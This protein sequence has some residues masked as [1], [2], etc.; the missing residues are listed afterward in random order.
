[1]GWC[2][3]AQYATK[4]ES[5]K[6]ASVLIAVATFCHSDFIIRL[7][8]SGSSR[9]LWHLKMG[10]MRIVIA[11]FLAVVYALIKVVKAA[12]LTY[13]HRRDILRLKSALFLF[14]RFCRAALLRRLRLTYAQCGLDSAEPL[15]KLGVALLY[16]LQLL[17]NRLEGAVHAG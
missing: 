4:H 16:R 15:R 17:H 9:S 11:A 8:A 7:L 12:E 6:V 14:F 2:Y 1:M 10:S 5:T 3:S 13:T